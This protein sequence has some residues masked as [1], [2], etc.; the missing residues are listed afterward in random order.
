[1]PML[2][3]KPLLLYVTDTD[4]IGGAEGYL[5]TLL[6]N[7]DQRRFRVGLLL[8]PR[9]AT[10][11]L[12]NQARAAGVQVYFLDYI[13]YEGLNLG[14]VVRAT[15]MLRLLRPEVIHF[16][17]PAPRRSAETVI[18]AAL[19]GVP[20]RLAT[21][22]LV[23]PVPRFGRLAGVV[24]GFN[25]RM[26]YATLH[27]AIAVSE[28]NR[29]LLIDQYGV[30]ARRLA[31]IPNAVDTTCYHPIADDGTLRVAWG[32]PHTAPLL[33]VV[34]RLV[35]T[36]G[37]HVLIDALPQVWEVFPETHIVFAGEGE[38]EAELRAR[39][40]QLPRGQQVH[41]IGKQQQ[42]HKLLATLD[43]FVLPSFV[44]GL[45]FA[46]LEALASECAVIA[47]AVDGTVE[48]IEHLQNGLLVPPGAATPLADA[49]INL[50]G[51]PALRKRMG[52]AARMRVLAD[53]DQQRMLE[54]T[55]ALY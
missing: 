8:P 12:V 2:Q 25:R 4:T 31:L 26:H 42:I 46:L 1:M 51:D 49:I 14:A 21:F 24:R 22:Q 39:A 6:L 40:A 20:R 23:T 36:K 37:Q 53:F 19:A 34:A 50:L 29:R 38:Q 30:A 10:Q 17:L 55:F 15:A 13:H 44:E 54:R 18:A 47:T 45:S 27:Q 41:F 11:P 43:L 33:G 5:H 52:N 48:V 32:I 7:A 16:V 28:G 9:P 35:R 3:T